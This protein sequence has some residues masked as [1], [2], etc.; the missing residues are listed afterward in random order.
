M[1]KRS[2]I[3]VISFVLAGFCV[4]GGFILREK[5]VS[6]G[7]R[8][9][10]QL[11]YRRALSELVS[12]S[13]MLNTALGKSVRLESPAAL[14]SS[15]TEGYAKAAAALSALGALP[16]SDA[17]LEYTAAFFSKA[18]DYAFV[19]SKKAASGEALS[20]EERAGLE[21]LAET[22]GLLAQNLSG[23]Y[24]DVSDGVIEF[25]RSENA[26]RSSSAA[27]LSDSFTAMEREFPELP[28]LIY[29][30]P[31]SEHLSG[32]SPAFLDD[33]QEIDG[34]TAIDRASE[35]TGIA[36]ERFT[37]DYIREDEIPVYVLSAHSLHGEMLCE[38]SRRGGVVTRIKNT[39]AVGEGIVSVSDGVMLAER[40]LAARGYA[41]MEKSYYQAE[42]GCVTVNFA[43]SQNGVICYPDLAKVTV[44]LDTGGIV[45]FES[46]G[47]VMCHCERC[48]PEVSVSQEE[49]E[50]R[51]S[52]G[53][54]ILSRGL[55]VIET[56]GKNEVL[57]H[58][59][60]CETEDGTHY[61]LYVNAETGAEEKL[62]LLLESE[63]GTLTV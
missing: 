1:I 32:R 61:I 25:E 41:S 27:V 15:C 60:K 20:D 39:R 18:G 22:A 49:A 3:R 11:G 42:G 13:D 14:S 48:L 46:L 31:F 57:C 51:V 30:G 5:A 59:F 24:T 37:V 7:Y 45:G 55:A 58:E 6:D 35:F 34:D 63:N 33:A 19:M 10:I 4:M 44:A 47:Y 54:E 29:D 38:V 36:K 23:L 9:Q 17:Q 21:K 8:M 56:S 28:S 52:P 2:Y 62:L 16:L 43:Y 12:A 40:F 26:L 50:A 53:L